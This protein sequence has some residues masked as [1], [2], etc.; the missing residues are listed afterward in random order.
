MSL[1]LERAGFVP[2]FVNELDD[3]A[4]STYVRNRVARYPHLSESGFQSSDVKSML[5]KGYVPE[6]LARISE[7]FARDPLDV[8]LIAG[9]PPCQ[10]FSGIGHRRSYGVDRESHPANSLYRDMAE[11]IGKI[12]PKAFLFENVRGLLNSRWSQKGNRGEVW[13]DV[14]KSFQLLEGYRVAAGLVYAREYGVPQNRPR[15][16]LVGL[17]SDVAPELEGQAEAHK[18]D[19]VSRG[20]LPAGTAKAP[21]LADLLGDLIDPD[22]VNGG[23]T[24][25]Y[26]EEIQNQTQEYYRTRPDGSI[27]RS[28]DKVTEHSYSKHSMHVLRKFQAMHESG[29]QIPEEFRTR[30]F[31]QR[32]LPER[33]VAGPT[34]T[35]TSLPDDYVHFSQ[36]RTLSV[37]EWARLQGF[38]DWYEFD[39]KRTTG[40]LRR[41]GNPRMGVFDRELPKYTQ[42]GNAVPV[43]MA[44]AVGTHLLNILR[45]KG[46]PVR[47]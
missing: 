25:R 40:G 33:W 34:I 15:V 1:G 17:R 44:E 24:L 5:S 18:L 21:D 20:F 14:Y 19:A 28:G 35:A 46:E 3:N 11:V 9:G 43:Q 22:Y 16:L 36:P 8:D 32:L 29:G 26:P 37:R 27:A 12:R 23:E 7:T 39:G 6:L 13:R 2:A 38:P 47:E 45:G 42:I 31:A 30:K 41:A 10:G 4:R